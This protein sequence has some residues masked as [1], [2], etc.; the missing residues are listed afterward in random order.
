MISTSFIPSP[1]SGIRNGV[2][3]N[4]MFTWI[5]GVSRHFNLVTSFLSTSGTTTPPK[6]NLREVTPC[7]LVGMVGVKVFTKSDAFLFRVEWKVLKLGQKFLHDVDI[8]LPKYSASQL[9]RL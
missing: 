8:Y 3:G 4:E 9:K 5:S 2:S 1:S 7:I 6:G